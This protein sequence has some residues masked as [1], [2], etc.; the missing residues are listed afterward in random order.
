MFDARQYLEYFGFERLRDRGENV[1]ASCP[2]FEGKHPRGDRRPS[3]GIH[4]VSGLANCFA[5]SLHMNLEQL[6]AKLLTRKLGERV[7]EYKAW[8]WL[9]RQNWVPRQLTPEELKAQLEQMGV[10]QTLEVLPESVLDQFINGVHPSIIVNRGITVE[11]AKFWELRYDSITRRTIIP[12][13]NMM[14]YLVGLLSRAT[15]PDDYIT[16]AVGVPGLKGES[17]KY[18]FKKGLVLY[19]ENR[20]Y[21]HDTVIVVES[22]LDVIYGWSHGL[23]ELMD[24]VALMG[25]KPSPIHIERLLPYRRVIL[26]LDNDYSGQEGI[27]TLIRQLTGKT[28]LFIFDHFGAKDLG[29][30]DSEELVLIPKYIK[31]AEALKL[32]QM[33]LKTD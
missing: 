2:D 11:M 6:T 5:C 20:A 12:V 9:E 24:I 25:A 14:G 22:P 29:E 33:K 16:H 1:M 4:K 23:H 7:D 3:F 27:Q 8:L 17:N 30:V 15:S 21:N 10:D 28:K 31:S 13:R 32:K 26:A 19:G 18:F